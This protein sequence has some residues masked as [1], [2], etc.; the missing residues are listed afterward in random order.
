MARIAFVVTT[1]HEFEGVKVL[2]SILKQHGHETDC[3][4]TSEEKDFHGAVERWQPD[5]LAVY[6]TTGQ[7]AWCYPNIAL[8]KKAL[9]HLKVVV[10]GPHPSFDNSQLLDEEY[11]DA[12]TKGEAEYAMLDLVEA[13]GAGRSI[14][15]IPNV[16]HLE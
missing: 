10:G 15:D 7:E 11:V 14:A 16:G 9:P 13:W 5:V 8:W 2:S 12:T 4:I 3:F 1:C 6:A